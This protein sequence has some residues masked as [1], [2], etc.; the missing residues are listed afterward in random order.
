MTLP[1]FGCDSLGSLIGDLKSGY[2]VYFDTSTLTIEKGETRTFTHED[3][4]FADL[5]E[6]VSPSEI[7]FS[8]SSSDSTVVGAA[9]KTIT[10]RS[11]GKTRVT[12]T[13]AQG[14]KAYLDVT[15]TETA[16]KAELVFP[17]G[18]ILPLDSPYSVDAYL[19]LDD[20]ARSVSAYKIEWKVDGS[21]VSFTGNPLTLYKKSAG[22]HEITASIVSDGKKLTASAL[23]GYVEGEIPSPVIAVNDKTIQKGETAGFSLEKE[24]E[25][26]EW[27]VNGEFMHEGK[28]FGFEAQKAG[29]FEVYAVCGDKSSAAVN[30]TVKGEAVASDV[31]ASYD[32]AYPDLTI[33]WNGTNGAKYRVTA[34]DGEN[35]VKTVITDSHEAVL[36]LDDEKSY[37]IEVKAV[38]DEN[39]SSG[40]AAWASV[41]EVGDLEKYYL[42]KKYVYGNSYIS[43]EEEFFDFFDYMMYFRK[44]PIGIKST[45]WT[46]RVYMAFDYGDYDDL[47]SRAFEYSG[48]TGSYNIGGSADG[49]TATV[50]IEFY[51][52]DTPSVRSSYNQKYHYDS[53]DAL[54]VN[55]RVGTEI[56]YFSA[57]KNGKITVSTTD[58]M[59]RVA[60]KGYV[61]VPAVGTSAAKVYEYA[62][63]VLGSIVCEE[64]SD[65]EIAR[66]I[67]EYIMNKNTY[68]GGVTDLGIEQSVKSASFY[69]ESVLIESNEKSGKTYGVCDAMSKTYAFLCNM[70]NVKAVRVTGYAGS[71]SDKG[72]HAWNKVLLD[73]EWYVV[74]CTWGDAGIKISKKNGFSTVTERL[75][76]ASH[77]Y[78]LLIDEDVSSTHVEDSLLYPRSSAIPY[79]YFARE[80]AATDKASTPLYLQSSGAELSSDLGVVAS[81]LVKIAGTNNTVEA[82][83]INRGDTF[84]GIEFS[85]CPRSLDQ[86]KKIL[87]D[88]KL[89]C[90]F[91][92]TLSRAGYS[93]N[94]FVDGN[95]FFVVVADE[96]VLTNRVLGSNDAPDRPFWWWL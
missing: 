79:G 50:T 2:S 15:V 75:E 49:K 84:R 34:F 10:A 4:R 17:L 69:M 40:E 32:D 76:S 96:N 53:L 89:T 8:L 95:T 91:Y 14:Y 93:Y 83:G 41:E 60:E 65:E 18:R 66:A 43:D 87:G 70:A 37:K 42:K 52:V 27:Y 30:M 20:G 6:N 92:R 23:A 72:G 54:P 12:L 90:K 1:F 48:I 56:N 7:G 3:L 46:E 29:V 59:Y 63:K 31:T 67:Y 26:A 19:S 74:D 64:M 73:G 35:A 47:L 55:Y 39:F 82:Y 36:S 24:F 44:Q 28:T 57:A 25:Y 78:F 5:S 45:R 13:T 58:Q 86:A 51:T 11:A 33:K 81:Y 71:G 94:A 85:V 80:T 22:V 16:H 68:D 62:K 61:P 88:S 38:A 9:G 21:A 77:T